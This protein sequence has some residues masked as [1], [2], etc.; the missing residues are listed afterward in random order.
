[1]EC[2]EAFT[3]CPC[4]AAGTRACTQGACGGRG[5]VRSRREE[6]LTERD[7]RSVSRGLHAVDHH[8]AIT[9]SMQAVRASSNILPKDNRHCTAQLDAVG[10]AAREYHVKVAVHA[11][12]LEGVIQQDYAEPAQSTHSLAQSRELLGAVELSAYL[13]TLC[14]VSG[15]A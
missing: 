10:C 4:H 12:V 7:K 5:V 3:Q 15:R 9:E 1:M 13:G 14:A 8:L 11:P 6:A 2:A